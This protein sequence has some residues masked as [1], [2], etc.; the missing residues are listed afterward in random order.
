MGDDARTTKMVALLRE[1]IASPVKASYKVPDEMRQ[2]GIVPRSY[3]QI[4]CSQVPAFNQHKLGGK[5]ALDDTLDAMV[6]N[7][8]L[9]EVDKAKSIEAYGFQGRAFR[10]TKLP[11]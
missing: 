7:G 8:Y 11:D 2:S 4:R 5:R 1:Y 3:L 10:I 9:F 6:A